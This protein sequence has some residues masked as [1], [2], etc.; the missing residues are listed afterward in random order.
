M[1]NR[2][3]RILL[4]RRFVK[5]SRDPGVVVGLSELFL[6]ISHIKLH[7]IQISNTT[8]DNGSSNL[9]EEPHA[10]N[11]GGKR[12]QAELER[13]RVWHSYDG[14]TR[15]K[16]PKCFDDFV[17]GTSSSSA[18]AA[19]ATETTRTE[20]SSTST[21]KKKNMDKSPG[22]VRRIMTFRGILPSNSSFDD[23]AFPLKTP[24][25][26]VASAPSTK[27]LKTES[28][29]H[30]TAPF[31]SAMK[32]LNAADRLVHSKFGG[33]VHA[34]LADVEASMNRGVT[35]ADYAERHIGNSP[36]K[37][38]IRRIFAEMTGGVTKLGSGWKNTIKE[39]KR[40]SKGA[41]T[42]DHAVEKGEDTS[43]QSTVNT[44]DTEDRDT[45]AFLRESFGSDLNAFFEHVDAEIN[46]AKSSAGTYAT[47]HGA[48]GCRTT[49]SR[50]A[51]SLR[52]EVLDEVWG[53]FSRS[54]WRIRVD[55][56]LQQKNMLSSKLAAVPAA[57]GARQ[58]N[59]EAHSKSP[60]KSAASRAESVD[61]AALGS[62]GDLIR[63]HF[64]SDPNS[65]MADLDSRVNYGDVSALAY[66]ES[67]GCETGHSTIRRIASELKGVETNVGATWKRLLAAYLDGENSK[68]R[69]VAPPRPK[70]ER[71]TDTKSL[72]TTPRFAGQEEHIRYVGS[73][74]KIGGMGA[75]ESMIELE[76]YG[77]IF[78]FLENLEEEMRMPD[79]SYTGYLNRYN[80]SRA[81]CTLQPIVAALRGDKDVR[82]PGK[83]WSAVLREYSLHKSSSPLA[84]TKRQIQ[85]ANRT[86]MLADNKPP[87]GFHNQ[88]DD[89][90]RR[91]QNDIQGRTPGALD[92]MIQNHFDWKYF[93]FL[94]TLEAEMEKPDF[95][96]A[97]FLKNYGASEGLWNLQTI[98]A[99]LKGKGDD[100]LSKRWF[101][102]IRAYRA[103]KGQASGHRR[104]STGSAHAAGSVSKPTDFPSSVVLQ[105]D[106]LE[107]QPSEAKSMSGPDVA[108]GASADSFHEHS[109]PVGGSESGHAHVS[110]VGSSNGRNQTG[111]PADREHQAEQP[112]AIARRQR[113]PE[114]T[115]EMTIL[116]GV[117]V[118]LALCGPLALMVLVLTRPQYPPHMMPAQYYMPPNGQ[119]AMYYAGYHGQQNH[120]H[121]NHHHHNQYATYSPPRYDGSPPVA[122]SY[123]V[124]D[125]SR[126][127]GQYYYQHHEP[128][129]YVRSQTEPPHQ[130]H[131]Q[132]HGGNA[133][134]MS[135]TEF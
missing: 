8:T 48:E 130:V 70:E 132:A 124:E 22:L 4:V 34:F 115:L 41:T 100:R 106:L 112:L 21:S 54:V 58:T 78:A 46:K 92:V 116:L 88:G 80:A 87:V 49:L 96:S 18:R 69:P 60:A 111:P 103:R 59:S 40:G 38:T 9:E 30:T 68:R 93:S 66:A 61:L 117:L 20:M 12:K 62:V 118:V 128:S 56:Y 83:Y 44:Q 95:A 101:G 74:S 73:S 11:Q 77:D 79:F 122:S 64:G 26:Y 36:G 123:P 28:M 19:A 109:P 75:L 32:G 85:Q 51:R 120:H 105:H 10:K 42:L 5:G 27:K 65:F 91:F 94:E 125:S 90:G 63:Q 108:D 23:T 76:F 135:T 127:S 29:P 17:Y 3:Q 82:P 81:G 131:H 86:M 121:P 107:H 45:E 25:Q 43:E 55:E 114:L 99:E 72:P 71:I 129:Q 110:D 31:V 24:P 126:D 2:L 97:T 133:D 57:A 6:S 53:S 134:R 37:Q 119:A 7:S 15:R 16:I 35:A 84:N 104:L 39:Y 13:L 14:P 47:N 98:I 102:I 33:N 113:F 67:Y 50:I 52:G 1:L 89:Y